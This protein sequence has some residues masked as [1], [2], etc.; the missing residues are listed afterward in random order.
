MVYILMFIFYPPPA[1][2]KGLLC[3]WWTGGEKCRKNVKI[4]GLKGEAG[5]VVKNAS[6]E[7]AHEAAH[8][9]E[10]N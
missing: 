10:N 3:P 8:E 7:L 9:F 6:G 1:K 4:L 5:V 2:V